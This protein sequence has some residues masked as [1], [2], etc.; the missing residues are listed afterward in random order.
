[1]TPL[2]IKAR[3][4]EFSSIDDARI[5]IFIDDATLEMSESVWGSLYNKGLAY[6]TAH[7]LTI[8]GKTASGNSG[9][10]NTVASK[11]VEGVSQSFTTPSDISVK[12]SSYLST[13]YGQEYYRL[14]KLVSKGIRSV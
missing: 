6:F 12:N 10:L 14:L 9:S 5:Q 1:M 13:A 4:T 11:A 3:F 7:L 8:S 2:D